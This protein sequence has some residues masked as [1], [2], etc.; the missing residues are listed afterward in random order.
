METHYFCTFGIS[1][2]GNIYNVL[3]SVNI[4][5]YIYLFSVNGIWICWSYSFL[6]CHWH[7]NLKFHIWVNCLHFMN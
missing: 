4:Y 1:E 6:G 2:L 5:I 7:D 3:V